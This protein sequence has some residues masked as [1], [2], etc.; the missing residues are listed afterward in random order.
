MKKSGNKNKAETKLPV[1]KGSNFIRK[2]L[3]FLP[4]ALCVL[5][6]VSILVGEKLSYVDGIGL[7]LSPIRDNRPLIIGLVIFMCGYLL[8]V[9]ILYFE[10]LKEFFGNMSKKKK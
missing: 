7:R 10:N 1:K 4:L 3:V 9:G 5:W 2:F 8:F 6:V